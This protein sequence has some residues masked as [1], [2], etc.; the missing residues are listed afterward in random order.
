MFEFANMSSSESGTKRVMVYDH[1]ELVDHLESIGISPEQVNFF[2]WRAL[3]DRSHGRFLVWEKQWIAE[4]GAADTKDTVTLVIK[5]ITPS[6]TE[7]QKTFEVEVTGTA[8]LMSPNEKTTQEVPPEDPENPEDPPEVVNNGQDGERLLLIE[9][10]LNAGMYHKASRRYVQHADFNN[11]KSLFANGS[12]FSV[13]PE[14]FNRYTIPDIPLAD[15]LAYLASTHFLT[16]YIPEG[17]GTATLTNSLFSYPEPSNN[18]MLFNKVTT[19][20]YPPK[21]KIVL[22][23][24]NFCDPEFFKSDDLVI[25]WGTEGTSAEQYFYQSPVASNTEVENYEVFIPFAMVDHIKTEF[26]PNH[27]KGQAN[28]FRSVIQESYANTR[29]LRDVDITYQGLVLGALSNDVQSITYYFQGYDGGMRTRLRS[30]PWQVDNAILAPRDVKCKDYL[31][32]G[33]LL[34]DMDEN[35]AGMPQAEAVVTKILNDQFL[36]DRKVV[37]SDPL[38]TFSDLKAGT[39]VYLYRECTSCDY[40]IIQ[41]ECPPPSPLPTS[42]MGSCCVQFQIEDDSSSSYCYETNKRA[43]DVLGGTF[44]EDGQCPDPPDPPYCT[45]SPGS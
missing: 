24:N 15:Y 2:V 33:V 41:S 34:T 43:C 23:D 17:G 20:K 8:F 37:V 25:L 30:I 16:A 6:G 39:K 29:L 9:V 4:F 14:V 3:P 7:I 40:V 44:I 11:L 10:E 42:P 45:T 1:T 18:P 12:M 35:E 26:D 21:I 27:G 5:S 31:F 19:R 22:Q 13:V 32:K 38:G 28:R 36:I